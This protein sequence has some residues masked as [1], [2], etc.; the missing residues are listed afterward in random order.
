[1]SVRVVISTDKQVIQPVVVGGVDWETEW[2]GAP[3]KLEF[4]VL[5]DSILGEKGFYEGDQVILF[6]DDEIAFRG[7]IFEKSRDREQQIRVVAYDQLRYFANKDTITYSNKTA[8]EVLRQICGLGNFVTGELADTK[9]RIASRVEDNQTYWDMIYNALDLTYDSTKTEYVLYD[10]AGNITLSTLESL[11]IND[12]VIDASKTQNFEYRTSIDQDTYTYIKLRQ[13]T[14]TQNV[15][16]VYIVRDNTGAAKWG[17]LNLVM[18]I[19]KEENAVNMANA[20][21]QLKSR[22]T[23][24]LRLSGVKGDIRVRGGSTVPVLL[25]LGDTNEKRFYVVESARHNITKDI[26]T[27]DLTLYDA[28]LRDQVRNEQSIEWVAKP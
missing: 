16:N 24:E 10:K 20:L 9:F 2:K 28:T 27:M 17:Q 4:S 13:E 21:I 19:G 6:M 14:D 18:D 11:K 3:A 25:N 5:K 23:R 12:F 7:F 8:T 26:H 1:M 22:K 15:R